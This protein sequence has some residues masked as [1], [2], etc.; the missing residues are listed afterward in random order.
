MKFLK[1]LKTVL[2]VCAF[3]TS[4]LSAHKFFTIPDDQRVITKEEIRA[5]SKIIAAKILSELNPDSISKIKK[6]GAYGAYALVSGLCTG[7]I[8]WSYAS[9][10]FSDLK[11]D[12]VNGCIFGSSVLAFLWSFV[13][14]EIL[15]S[16]V[17]DSIRT[18]EDKLRVLEKLNQ[19]LIN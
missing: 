11:D 3:C 17:F 13:I 5:E 15:D 18:K 8:V 16:I 10:P 12:G 6:H 1:S 19:D 14:L 9:A 7:I 2:L 4:G